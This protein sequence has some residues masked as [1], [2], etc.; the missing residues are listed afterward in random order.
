MLW[1]SAQTPPVTRRLR[2]HRVP[3]STF[4]T[5]RT[6]LAIEAGRLHHNHI[7]LKNVSNIFFAPR[8]D[9][10]S[11]FRFVKFDL[12]VGQAFEDNSLD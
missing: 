10:P 1:P 2:I 6:P 7:I 3:R 8:L 11:C 9:S 12:P 4:V 5:T